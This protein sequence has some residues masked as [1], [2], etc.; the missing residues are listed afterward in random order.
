MENQEKLNQLVD[1]TNI[2]KEQQK[3]GSK[4]KNTDKPTC[5]KYSKG[6]SKNKNKSQ[7]PV[8]P[9]RKLLNSKKN[10]TKQKIYITNLNAK[11]FSNKTKITDRLVMT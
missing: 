8:N 10:Y 11:N 7:E 3:Q 5:E 4:K 9:E 1:C 6:I 2:Y